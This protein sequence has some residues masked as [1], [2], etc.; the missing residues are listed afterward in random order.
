MRYDPNRYYQYPVLRPANDDYPDGVFETQ[1]SRT[2]DPYRLRVDFTVQEPT[3]QAIIA[4]GNARCAAMAYCSSTL[5]SV[6][7]QAII[8]AYSLEVS[9]P[10]DEVEGE[11]EVWSSIITTVDINLI[12]GTAHP[13]YGNNP[14][15]ITGFKPLALDERWR[16]PLAS[17]PSLPDTLFTLNSREDLQVGEF[18]ID[19]DAAEPYIKIFMHDETRRQFQLL[20]DIPHQALASVFTAALVQ[21]LAKFEANDEAIDQGWHRAIRQKLDEMGIPS[22]EGVEEPWRVAQLIFGRPYATILDEREAESQGEGEL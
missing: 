8:G 2:D 1:V 17:A 16:V 22:E 7:E 11:I 18:H 9:I 13:E 5:Y 14:I 6:M 3:I 12:T 10:R 4:D 15:Q 21:V 19:A 20:R